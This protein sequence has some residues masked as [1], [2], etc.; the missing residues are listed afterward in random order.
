MSSLSAVSIGDPELEAHLERATAEIVSFPWQSDVTAEAPTAELR[1]RRFVYRPLQR[2]DGTT[3]SEETAISLA[4]RIREVAPRDELYTD[5]EHRVLR[6]LRRGVQLYLYVYESFAQASGLD[7]LKSANRGEG[8][9]GPAQAELQAKLEA[10]GAASLFA[11][12]SYVWAR[13][14]GTET[15]SAAALELDPPRELSLSGKTQALRAGLHFAY[16]AIDAHARDDV[17]LVA[18]VRAAA[19]AVAERLQTL[20]HSLQYLE[21]YTRYHYRVE[22]ED[23]S[24]AGFE[25]SDPETRSDVQVPSRRPEEVVGNHLAKL[26]AGRI[27]QRLACYDLEHQSNPF[28]DLGGFTFS[29][30]GDGSPGTGKTTLIQMMVSL[31]RGYTEVAGVPLRYE[32]FSVDEISDYQ[33]R[34]GHNAKRFCQTVLDPHAIGFGTIDDVDQVC[35]NRHDRN[36][37]AGQLEVTA[38]FMQ[39]LGGAKTVVRGN[40]C[41]GLFSN[42]PEKV[43]DALRQR[44]QG[45]FLVD[46]PQTAD[47]FTD[48]LHILLAGRFELPRGPGYEPLAAQELRRNVERKYGEHGVPASPELRRIFDAV[49]GDGGARLSS[50]RAFG[51]Y[52]HA[53]HRE[54]PRFTGRAIKNISDAVRA[55]VMNFDL[56][57]EWLEKR[58]A[59]FS[60]PYETRVAMIEE[61]RGAITPEIVIQEINRYADSEARY[62]NAAE[63]RALEDRTQQILIDAKARKAAAGEL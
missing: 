33:G 14:A 27:A 4:S 13:L 55:R 19:R 46:G 5:T 60:R 40:A 41:F 1:G 36:A 23:V 59:F 56:P 62:A 7:R 49:A 57:V 38:V 20:Q 34:S 2:T 43:D 3:A 26:E 12:Q 48:L 42:Y 58:E 16:Q 17:S 52:L 53:L 10:A 28:V 44:M 35:G 30:I 15:G 24:I 31:L 22:P 9:A 51:D 6:V 18:S 54:N 61:L 21:F 47:D 39:E 63:E 32:N 29:F 25:L 45:R 11:F 8:L 50:W 37:S